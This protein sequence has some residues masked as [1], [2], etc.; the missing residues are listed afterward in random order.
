MEN[1]IDPVWRPDGTEPVILF[2]Y[3]D[4]LSQHTD[5]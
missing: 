2:K 3:C 4:W 5:V 1:F